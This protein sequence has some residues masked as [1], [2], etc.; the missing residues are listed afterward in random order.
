[1]PARDHPMELGYLEPD[2]Q[3]SGLEKKGKPPVEVVHVFAD[4]SDA[5][6]QRSLF[7]GPG[8]QTFTDR[9]T[10]KFK[11]LSITVYVMVVRRVKG[12]TDRTD[13]F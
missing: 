1:M 11:G 8:R 6:K 13:V 10:I 12:V 4:K 2:W 9:K 7:Q 5:R 3:L